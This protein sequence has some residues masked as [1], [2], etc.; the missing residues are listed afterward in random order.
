[1]SE[2]SASLALTKKPPFPLVAQLALRSAAAYP[3]NQ[4]SM[5]VKIAEM[6]KG[7]ARFESLS[8]VR[9][10]FDLL[11]LRHIRGQLEALQPQIRRNW[12]A[13]EA[14]H[15]LERLSTGT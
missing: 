13:S 8:S 2:E 10:G 15:I 5:P 3:A 11:C 12:N 7:S 9:H 14:S 1:M 6:A 4:I